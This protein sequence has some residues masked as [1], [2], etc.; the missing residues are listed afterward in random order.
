V[1]SRPRRRHLNARKIIGGNSPETFDELRR[2]DE[3]RS[4]PQFNDHAAR[5]AV[6]SSKPRARF[7]R[8]GRR[9]TIQR[10]SV[11]AIKES[12]AHEASSTYP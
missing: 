2:E 1:Q 8:V 6:E 9:R 4:I 12:I 7:D 10:P 11:F 3:S 5:A